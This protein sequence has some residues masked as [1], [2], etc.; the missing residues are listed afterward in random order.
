MSRGSRR[1][2]GESAERNNQL[3]CSYDF[4]KSHVKKEVS[5]MRRSET[6]MSQI[7]QHPEVAPKKSQNKENSSSGITIRRSTR[8]NASVTSK[9][10]SK[11]AVENASSVKV[12]RRN[13]I[14]KDEK[15]EFTPYFVRMIQNDEDILFFNGSLLF[16]CIDACAELEPLNG[17]AVRQELVND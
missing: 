12:A 4:M 6:S 5:G 7:L 9:V 8:K 17:R 1:G 13:S 15:S 3:S 2:R 10:T 16:T 14:Q 11:A